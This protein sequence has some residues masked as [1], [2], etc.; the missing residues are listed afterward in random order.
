MG[1]HLSILFILSCFG[2]NAQ[3]D[4][5]GYSLLSLEVKDSSL[6][7]FSSSPSKKQIILDGFVLSSQANFETATSNDVLFLRERPKFRFDEGAMSISREDEVKMK[8]VRFPKT[9]LR[10]KVYDK[11]N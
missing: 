4:I 9:Y 5:S 3:T 1:N 8:P 7:L 2:L 11:C 6:G 10:I